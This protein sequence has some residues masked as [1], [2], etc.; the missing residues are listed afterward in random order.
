MEEL[1]DANDLIAYLGNLELPC[2]IAAALRDSL[3]QKPLLVNKNGIFEKRL[4][5]WLSAALENL[6]N[7]FSER[8]FSW[9][10]AKVLLDGV[11]QHAA[12]TKV[13]LPYISKNLSNSVQSLLPCTLDFL[14]AF[15]P[16]WDGYGC[17]D[18]ILGLLSFLPPTNFKR[19]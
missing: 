17:M 19:K 9:T 16:L 5:L 4:N 10:N 12:L 2:Q 18:E 1:H 13:S 14:H 15:V 7:G 6:L 11:L 3:L 8:N